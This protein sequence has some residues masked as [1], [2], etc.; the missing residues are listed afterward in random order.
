[1]PFVA[2]GS[3]FR[4]TRPSPKSSSKFLDETTEESAMG[5]VIS[6]WNTQPKTGYTLL[7]RMREDRTGAHIRRSPRHVRSLQLLFLGFRSASRKDPN[8]VRNELAAFNIFDE[9][10]LATIA[11]FRSATNV[12]ALQAAALP[13]SQPPTPEFSSTSRRARMASSPARRSPSERRTRGRQAGEAISSALVSP[14]SRRLRRQAAHA[15][16]RC[17]RS[18]RCR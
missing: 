9:R 14:N 13:N 16:S 4:K 17:R 12:Y 8:I 3:A 15:G 6:D 7:R 2:R 10:R 5:L 11:L 1:M 18:L